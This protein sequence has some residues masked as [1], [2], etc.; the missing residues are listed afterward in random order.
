[1]EL[2]FHKNLLPG[3]QLVKREVRNLEET[4]EL[5]LPDGMPDISTVVGAWAQVLLR[6]KEWHGNSAQVSGGAMVCVL[7]MPEEGDDVQKVETWMPFQ[8]KWELPDTQTEGMICADAL[9]RSA[10][11]RSICARKLMVRTNVGVMGE[12]WHNTEAWTYAPGDLPED[13]A[14]L[15]RNYPVCLPKEAGEKPFVLEEEL[16]FPAGAPKPVTLLRCHLQPELTD[17]KILSDK[18]VFRG[19]MLVHALYRGEDGRIHTWDFE[20]P[21]SQYSEL[22]REYEADAA[23]RLMMA[24]TSME[25]DMDPEGRLRL[26]VGITAQYLICDRINLET[27]EDAYS[28]RRSVTPQLQTLEL[29]VVLDMQHQ[30][31]A[32]EQTVQATGKAV[33][34][35]FLPDHPASVHM[36]APATMSGQFQY[37]YRDEDDRLQTTLQRWEQPVPWNSDEDAQLLTVIR[38]AG[39]PQI[40]FDGNATLLHADMLTEFTVLSS[41]GIPMVTALEVGDTLESDE[42]RPSLI[43]RRAGDQSLWQ[44]AK[45]NGSTVEAIMEANKLEAQP[46]ADKMLLIPVI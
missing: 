31:T 5:R 7:Y 18:V 43:L 27:V 19:T 26:K 14:V 32:A 39:K 36:G 8:A 6:S 23:A 42:G 40:A 10:D 28:P 45:E 38:P 37:L 3:M 22:S 24:L 9:L 46:D 11:A 44:I 34:L 12:F 21:F 1:M 41:G 29:P 17:Q 4:Q 25:A 30:I 2:Q 15:R 33:D 13:I 35:S 16:T 20:V